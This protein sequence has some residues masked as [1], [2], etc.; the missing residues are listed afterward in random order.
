MSIRSRLPAAVSAAV[1]ASRARRLDWLWALGFVLLWYAVLRM[2]SLWLF[3]VWPRPES[4][5]RDLSAHLV[6]GLVL[7]FL[8]RNLTWYLV[9]V[10]VLMTALHLSNAG[11]IVVLGGPIMPDDF[12][13]VGNLFKLLVG[14]QW[15]AAV[16]IIAVP[17]TLMAF[18]I[19]WRTP[20]TWLLLAALSAAGTAMATNPTSVVHAMDRYFGNI[21]WNQ[22]GNFEGRGLFIHLL[23]ETARYLSRSSRPPN[24][25]TV[26][27]ALLYVKGVERS[28]QP[29]TAADTAKRRNV[30]LILLESFWD[31]TLLT[32]A[33]LSEDPLDPEFRRLWGE[34]GHSH[35]LSPVFGGYTAN[36]EFEVLCGFPVSEDAVFFE[37]WLRRDVP[38]LPRH[39]GE[40]GYRTVVSHPN[41]AA[42]WN[43]VN[44]Y[45]RVGFSTYWAKDEFDMDDMNGSF[46]SDESLYRQVMA[47]IEPVLDSGTPVFNYILTYFGHLHYPLNERRPPV[48]ETA[49]PD[50]LTHAY[51][52]TMYYKSRELMAFLRE[53]RQRDPQALIIM[54]GDHLPFLGPNF[55]GFTE[56]GLLADNRSKF[57][58]QMFRTLVS[59]PL[60]VIDGERGPLRVGDVPLYQLPDLILS[61]LGDDRESFLRLTASPS[62]QPRIRPL[63]GMYYLVDGERVTMCK[64]LS[65]DD[66][67]CALTRA[68][69]EAVSVLTQDAFGGDQHAL[70]AARPV[71]YPTA[72]S[73]Q[74]E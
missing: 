48:I 24:Q 25:T 42:F 8:A 44:A 29:A 54:L 52:N 63:P 62:L 35:A 59:T 26:G 33:K 70:Q 12:I 45:Q 11:K 43:R 34:T 3:Q 65:E 15:L 41:V 14:W 17:A 36:A 39:L 27:Q 10:G 23:Q 20:R 69:V 68:W 50:T 72:L 13:A 22:R 37:G 61:L 9:T 30:H 16:L 18:M 73:K 19:A 71:L 55:A 57:D 5:V 21:V 66:P 28:R 32:A 56:S 64:Q 51:V 53:L 2:V 31:P 60:I 7:Y 67:D 47:K 6:L 1:A 46:L 38:C 58:K 4:L 49:V 40:N 74:G